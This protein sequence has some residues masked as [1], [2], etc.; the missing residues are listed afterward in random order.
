[1]TT[2]YGHLYLYWK[3]ARCFFELGGGGGGRLI[4]TRPTLKEDA[5]TTKVTNNLNRNRIP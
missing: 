4:E 5:T 1:M 2:V 3:G